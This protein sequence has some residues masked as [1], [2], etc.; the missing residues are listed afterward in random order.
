M[1]K[2]KIKDWLILAFLSGVI[3]TLAMDAVNY[4]FYKR[5]KIKMMYGNMAGSVLMSGLRVKRKENFLIGQI[6]HML[7]GGML[8]LFS[9]MVLKVSGKDNYIIKGLC[10]G[11][12]IWA[13]VNNLS[14]RLRIFRTTIRNSEGYYIS[15]LANITYGLVT[16]VLIV[17]LGNPSMFKQSP[18][19]LEE[20]KE[21]E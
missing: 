4:P 6:Y 18:T 9:F 17:L 11:A 7:T 2:Y 12:I 20:N 16:T 10:S 13:T 14:Q 5:K 19:W 3:G 1:I 15:L 21:Q 8:G